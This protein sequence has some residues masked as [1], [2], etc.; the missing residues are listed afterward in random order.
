MLAR[1]WSLSIR[2]PSASLQ[3]KALATKYTTIKWPIDREKWKKQ[4]SR[5]VST[6]L[7]IAFKQKQKKEKEENHFIFSQCEL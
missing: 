7:F 2:L 6:F 4:W 5:A 3:I 1:Y